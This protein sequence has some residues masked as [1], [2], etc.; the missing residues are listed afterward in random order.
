V[1]QP[2]CAPANDNIMELLIL[3]DALKRASA[4][5]ITAVVPYFG[6]ARQEEKRELAS[7]SQLN[8]LPIS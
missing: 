6:Y 7:R 4:Y 8:C 5:R 2:T 1:V 3:M